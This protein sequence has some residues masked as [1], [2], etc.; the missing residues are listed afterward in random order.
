M[1]RVVSTSN[2]KRHVSC[3]EAMVEGTTVRTV[4][5]AYF[6]RHPY[7]RGYVANTKHMYVQHHNGIFV[8]KDHAESWQECENVKPSAFGFAVVAHPHDPLTAWFVP[9]IKDEKRIPM[10]GKLVVTRTRDGGKSFEILRDGLPQE[11]A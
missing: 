4:L 10:D 6:A 11:H 3:P 2:L 5:E 9:G 1:P 7:V 8:S